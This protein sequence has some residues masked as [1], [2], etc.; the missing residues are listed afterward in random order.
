MFLNL[1]CFAVLSCRPIFASILDVQMRIC[2]CRMKHNLQLQCTIYNRQILL[3]LNEFTCL[4]DFEGCSFPKRFQGFTMYGIFG[5][6]F[7]NL[8]GS[9]L[10]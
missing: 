2:S 1:H 10:W 9:S 3:F 8:G 7:L 4:V 6:P 5:P